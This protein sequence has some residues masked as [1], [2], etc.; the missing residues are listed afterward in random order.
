MTSLQQGVKKPPTFHNRKALR[1][2]NH[3][4]PEN[5]SVFLKTLYILM[6]RST[7]KRSR[8]NMNAVVNKI[9][10]SYISPNVD[11]NNMEEIERRYFYV[12]GFLAKLWKERDSTTDWQK[13]LHILSD[14]TYGE[15]QNFKAWLSKNDYEA[16]VTTLMPREI[17]KALEKLPDSVITKIAVQAFEMEHHM[18]GYNNIRKERNEFMKN[19]GNTLNRYSKLT[20]SNVNP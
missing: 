18:D 4:I 19:H 7:R 8:L 6:Y 3:H 15:H 17:K 1:R 11:N 5:T 14:I 13:I 10:D 2:M 9:T 16:W 20:K 12:L